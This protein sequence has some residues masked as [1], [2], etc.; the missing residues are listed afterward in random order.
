MFSAARFTVSLILFC[1]VSGCFALIIHS[2][3]PFFTDLGK[4]SKFDRAI[5]FALNA[6]SRSGGMI[7]SSISSKAIQV[8]FCFAKLMAA[9]PGS[10]IRP[11]ASNLSTLALF[12]LLQLLFAFR[13][14]KNW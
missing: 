2:N 13:L 7:I 1:L 10:A 4:A 14:E 12:T 11:S 8:P 5:G 6:V 9:R 3:I